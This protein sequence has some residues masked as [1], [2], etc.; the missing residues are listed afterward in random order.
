MGDNPSKKRDHS[1]PETPTGHGVDLLFVTSVYWN[2]HL[3]IALVAILEPGP[4]RRMEQVSESKREVTLE[5]F[6]AK[7]GHHAWMLLPPPLPAFL[8]NVCLQRDLQPLW[9]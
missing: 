3:A 5:I 2:R 9:V 4:E 8:M 7:I 1:R 6:L